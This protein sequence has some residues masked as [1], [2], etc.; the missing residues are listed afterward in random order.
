LVWVY[1]P[2]KTTFCSIQFL[3]LILKAFRIGIHSKKTDKGEASV[4]SLDTFFGVKD[5]CRSET[6]QTYQESWIDDSAFT[7][8]AHGFYLSQAV[9]PRA[10]SNYQFLAHE[11]ADH[12]FRNLP[13]GQQPVKLLQHFG[14]LC[15]HKG[16]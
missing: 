14:R 1:V 5:N 12:F 9:Q 8:V 16:A 11:K 4:I 7:R 6:T 2:N 3:L 10:L 13:D 15:I